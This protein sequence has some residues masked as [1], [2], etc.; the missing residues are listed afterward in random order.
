MNGIG[1]TNLV[2]MNAS[3]LSEMA[4]SSSIEITDVIPGLTLQSFPRIATDGTALGVVWKQ[5]VNGTDQCVIRFTNNFM[6]GLPAVFDT[7]DL[8]NV[9]NT[10]LEV[11]DGNVHVIWQDDNSGTVKYRLGN[12]NST[13]QINIQDP[14]LEFSVAPN[15]AASS[16]RVTTNLAMDELSIINLFGQTVHHSEPGTQEQMILLN[17]PGIYFVTVKSNHRLATKLL[18]IMD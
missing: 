5:T 13:T 15:P 8:G 2:Y 1:G 14:Y 10:D 3:S 12:Y 4:G 7:V 9:I 11:D 17:E 18:T 6:N 16:V